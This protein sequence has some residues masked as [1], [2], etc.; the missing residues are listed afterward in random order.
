LLQAAS[1]GGF[2]FEPSLEHRNTA[3]KL[4]AVFF[5]PAYAYPNLLLSRSVHPQVNAGVLVAGDGWCSR[6][7]RYR[8]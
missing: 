1:F 6:S 3:Q 5:H 2:H 8:W 4:P 7:L